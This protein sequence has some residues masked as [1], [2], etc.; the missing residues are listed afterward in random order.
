MMRFLLPLVVV[1]SFLAAE[2]VSIRAGYKE[3]YT[4]LVVS[5]SIDLKWTV[6]D[7]LGAAIIHFEEDVDV[8]NIEDIFGRIPAKRIREIT[9]IDEKS[10]R[11]D[12]GCDCAVR[13]FQWRPNKFVVDFIGND[14]IFD[15]P[16]FR[17][18]NVKSEISPKISFR[19]ENEVPEAIIDSLRQKSL[20]DLEKALSQSIGAAATQGFLQPAERQIFDA[21]VA[22]PSDQSVVVGDIGLRSKTAF[23]QDELEND[24]SLI[25]SDFC[26]GDDEF[27]FLYNKGEEFTSKLSEFRRQ[28]SLAHELDKNLLRRQHADFLVRHGFGLEAKQKIEEASSMS[29][30]WTR[31]IALLVDKNT[32]GSKLAKLS[33]CEGMAQLVGVLSSRS[34]TSL[35]ADDAKSVARSYLR[36]APALQSRFKGQLARIL[37]RNDHRETARIVFEAPSN[38][39]D[40]R[41]S[42]FTS[43]KAELGHGAGDQDLSAPEVVDAQDLSHDPNL[44]AEIMAASLVEGFA[45][46]QQILSLAEVMAYEFRSESVGQK[47]QALLIENE[48]EFGDLR[49]AKNRMAEANIKEADSIRLDGKW[50][51]AVVERGEANIFLSTAF[52]RQPAG[53][54]GDVRSKFAKRLS[55]AGFGDVSD[56][57]NPLQDES[58]DSHIASIPPQPNI[59]EPDTNK[60]ILQHENPIASGHALLDEVTMLREN[61]EKIIAAK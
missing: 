56:I 39:V 13:S 10:I 37:L 18:S 21:E 26:P 3:E 22:T 11:V 5:T 54:P 59:A 57:W 52:E 17:E 30:D 31:D 25:Q 55:A 36:L 53:L 16:K 60:S 40:L 45:S 34:N 20:E 2:T 7:E 47:L 24:S 14:E 58:A 29:Y 50:M 8:E 32:K 27:D 35:T 4:R 23:A 1:P 19:E 9:Q 28:M 48:I 38:Y 49:S 43:V 33:R 12:L 46:D 44:V 42:D 61:I 51:R 15:R 6:D 41:D